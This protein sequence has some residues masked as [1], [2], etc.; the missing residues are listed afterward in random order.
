MYI[1]I[2][3]CST[4][5]FSR[6]PLPPQC[7]RKPVR[8]LLF[9]SSFS[10]KQCYLLPPYTSPVSMLALYSYQQSAHRDHK[11]TRMKWCQSSAQPP[12]LQWPPRLFLIW[13]LTSLLKSSPASILL[14]STQPQVLSLPSTCQSYIH[15]RLLR[16]IFLLTEMLFLNT[17]IINHGPSKKLIAHSNWV[18]E[19]R[20]MQEAFMKVWAES[21]KTNKD[22][23]VPWD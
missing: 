10:F 20:I 16:W 22:G 2:Y 19:E 8:G 1:Y 15:F 11:K 6:H 18:T 23:A 21:G 14:S 12:S 9:K 5:H 3:I 7:Q 13:L 4:A 17:S